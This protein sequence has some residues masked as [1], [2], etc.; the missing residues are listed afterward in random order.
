TDTGTSGEVPRAAEHVER[1]LTASVLS[2]PDG[3]PALGDPK[4]QHT[5]VV[6]GMA[7][8]WLAGQPTGSMLPDG[9]AGATETER[10]GDRRT[11]RIAGRCPARR[12]PS[13]A[14]PPRS[15]PAE[16]GFPLAP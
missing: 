1:P 5:V 13:R 16:R 6:P 11:F 12:W 14:R 4:G 7:D 9:N 10:A 15:L 2:C 3:G 8:V